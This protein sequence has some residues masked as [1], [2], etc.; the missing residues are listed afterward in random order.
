[1]RFNIPVLVDNSCIGQTLM[2]HP[3][4]AMTWHFESEWAR[5]RLLFYRSEEL[6]AVAR[7]Q[8]DK[9][10]T[11]P[12][13]ELGCVPVLG[14]LKSDAVL[15]SEEF[16]QLP[17]NIQKHISCS[18]VP[19]YEFALNCAVPEY[20]IDPANAVP[21]VPIVIFLMNPQSTG[22]CI[23]Q[24]SD[25]ALPLSYDPNFLSHPYDKRMAVESTRETMKIIKGSAFSKYNRG[26]VTGPES[27]GEEDILQFWRNN[28]SST[29]HMCGTVRMGKERDGAC[30]GN[31][32]RVFGIEA[33]RVSDMSVLPIMPK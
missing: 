31:D 23:L 15:D 10:Q 18:T 7:A 17:D 30:V 4:V 11:G 33:L 29:H 27:D 25:P 3:H 21:M 2:D 5:E 6:K 28:V 20:F 22:Q 1:M 32:F 13:S 16:H 9:D 8:W 14:F 26:M 12:L 19:T 24:S